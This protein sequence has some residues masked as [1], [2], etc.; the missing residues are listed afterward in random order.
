MNKKMANLKVLF[1]W[2]DSTDVSHATNKTFVQLREEE[3]PYY[4]DLPTNDITMEVTSRSEDESVTYFEQMVSGSPKLFGTFTK[5][6]VE[7]RRQK[8]R[9][10][11]DKHLDKHYCTI[12]FIM[13]ELLLCYDS[14][15]KNMMLASFGP[16]ANSDGNFVWYPIFYDIDTQLGLNNVGALL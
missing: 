9:N 2:L 11:F 13:T 3:H 14:R 12:Y 8:F 10:E 6:T 5:D 7:Y 4:V 1:D 16:T 15:G